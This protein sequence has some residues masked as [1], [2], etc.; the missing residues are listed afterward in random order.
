MSLSILLFQKASDQNDS[1]IGIS[2]SGRL[3]DTDTRAGLFLFC[4]TKP[5]KQPQQRKDKVTNYKQLC[6]ATSNSILTAG[7][8]LN[9]QGI[10]NV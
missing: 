10:Q 7:V 1:Y 5:Y 3:L 6:R 8:D 4:H 9:T 2:F